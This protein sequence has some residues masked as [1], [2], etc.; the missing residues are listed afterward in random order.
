MNPELV[1]VSSLTVFCLLSLSWLTARAS[2]YSS[3]SISSIFSLYRL[4]CSL[5]SISIHLQ[6]E[7][8]VLC[9]IYNCYTLHVLYEQ[10][11]DDWKANICT[12]KHPTCLVVSL[13]SYVVVLATSFMLRS[14]SAPSGQRRTHGAKTM[15]K[16]FGDMRL[17]ASSLHTLQGNL[18]DVNM[19]FTS[20]P[21]F[22][23]GT[24]FSLFD[25]IYVKC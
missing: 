24:G 19:Q 12:Q 5:M 20:T 13:Q 3:C 6:E 22:L 15:A 2:A 7:G 25:I 23:S 4:I 14:G 18:L 17:C 16:E 8:T 11:I 10:H 1:N 21:S 9:T